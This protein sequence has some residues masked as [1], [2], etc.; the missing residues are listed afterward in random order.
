MKQ[1]NQLYLWLAFLILFSFACSLFSTPPIE[2]TPITPEIALQT[3]STAQPTEIPAPK[4]P[5]GVVT[6]KDEVLSLY[7]REGYTL[8]QAD[9]SALSFTDESYLHLAGNFSQENPNLPVFYFSFEQNNSLLLSNNGQISTLLSTPNFSGLAGVDGEAIIAYSTTEFLNDSLLSNLYV[10]TSQSLPIV[11]SVLSENSAEGWGLSALA[12]DAEEG[13]PTGI[14]YSR[15]PWGIGGDI[16]FEPRRTLSYLDLRTGTVS[17]FLGVDANPSAISADR[18]WL[19]YTNDD[20][21]GASLGSMTIRNIET[22]ENLSYLLQNAIDQRGAG[23][24][25]FSPN[26]QYLAWMEGSGWQMAETP[27]FHSVIR[28]GDRNGNV[29]AEFADTSFLAVSGMTVVQRVEPVGW[30]D[31]ETLIIMVRGEHW[32]E[33]VLIMFDLPSQS[34]SFLAHGVFIGF[35]YP[36]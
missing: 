23:R 14:W 15:R 21:A 2:S 8:V 17:Q 32:D 36:P 18:K 1:K 26:N 10:G 33:A 12:V 29:V 3:E 5:L 35:V 16:V 20:S 13:Q 19:A 11:E 24:A 6:E 9:V 27:S 4:L 7:D 34:S 25:S 30:L 22:G 28:V 31:N